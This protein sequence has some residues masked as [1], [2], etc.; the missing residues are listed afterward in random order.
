[1]K[2][3]LR[4]IPLNFT[5]KIILCCLPLSIRDRKNDETKCI[6]YIGSDGNTQDFEAPVSSAG[7]GQGVGNLCEAGYMEPYWLGKK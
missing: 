5:M 6:R 2:I 3:C 7:L 4:I 1:M